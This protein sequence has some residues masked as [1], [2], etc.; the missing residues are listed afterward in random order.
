[1]INKKASMRARFAAAKPKRVAALVTV[2]ESDSDLP[3]IQPQADVVLEAWLA[4]NQADVNS[5]LRKRGGVRFRGFYDG[6]VEEFERFNA[7]ALRTPVPYCDRSSPRTMVSEHVY[8]STD[9]PSDQTIHMHSELSYSPQSPRRLTFYCQVPADSGGV[10]PLADNRSILKALPEET[11]TKF[12]KLGVCYRRKLTPEIGL[13]W[14]EAFSAQTREEAESRCRANDMSFEWEA[15]NVLRLQ[16][17]RPATV[18]HRESG[19]EIWFNHAFFFHPLSLPDAVRHQIDASDMPFTACF[20][21]G[22]PITENE[23]SQ[24]MSAYRQATLRAP[25]R[26]GDVVLLDNEL[27]SHGRD[28]FKGPRRILVAL[29]D[30]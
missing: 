1:M 25:W 5:L 10:T 6:S 11:A 15:E 8:T 7:V 24:I 2:E 16:W 12:R 28:P 13:R 17:T 19:Q 27:V 20:G 18:R 4:D 9:Y 14:Q 26:R 30:H 21:D 29:G 3:V 23:Y 22:S